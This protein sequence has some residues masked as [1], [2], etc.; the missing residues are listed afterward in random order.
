MPLAG[1]GA[2][3]FGAL[4]SGPGAGAF[5]VDLTSATGGGTDVG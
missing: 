2:L 5:T 1:A 3:S 4:L